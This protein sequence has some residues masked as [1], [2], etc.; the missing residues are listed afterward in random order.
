MIGRVRSLDR[1]SMRSGRPVR[2]RGRMKPLSRQDKRHGH[3]T[4]KL[5]DR[6]GLPRAARVHQLVALAFI[7]PRPEGMSGHRCNGTRADNRVEN[8]RYDTASANVA[9]SIRNGKNY[10][11]QVTHCPRGHAYDEANTYVCKRGKRMCRT[12]SADRMRAR[13]AAAKAAV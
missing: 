4:T 9:D 5:T 2:R 8:L 10:R 6:D 7:G 12:C 11:S 3:L 1:V 13:R